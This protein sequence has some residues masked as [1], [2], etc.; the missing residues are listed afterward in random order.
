M[1]VRIFISNPIIDLCA[2]VFTHAYVTGILRL[3]TFIEWVNEMKS[4]E[5]T[6]RSG[7]VDSFY[8]KVFVK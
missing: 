3:Y 7:P 6:L 1:P 4:T 5:A 2:N 8:D